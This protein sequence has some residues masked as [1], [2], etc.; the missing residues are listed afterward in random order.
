M[1]PD[2]R[3]D[4]LIDSSYDILWKSSG[5]IDGQIGIGLPADWVQVNDNNSISKSPNLDIDYKYDAFR[6]SM[7]IGMDYVWTGDMRAKNYLT[8]SGA[9]NFLLNTLVNKGQIN[10]EYRHDGTPLNDYVNA[11]TYA[12]NVGWFLPDNSDKVNQFKNNM[13]SEYQKNGNKFMAGTNYYMENLAWM[14]YALATGNAPNI[15][16]RQQAASGAPALLAA[17]VATTPSP[18]TAT[19][20]TPTPTPVSTISATIAPSIQ[21]TDR[22]IQVK[23]PVDN[24]SINGRFTMQIQNTIPNNQGTWWSVDS[25]GWVGMNNVGNNEWVSEIDISGWNWSPTQTYTL[26]GWTK[27]QNGNQIHTQITIHK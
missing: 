22:A 3:W 23:F 7:R 11:A 14:G 24:Q 21:T 25:G 1:N 27:D 8:L 4:K 9:H 2:P 18:T 10:T 17:Q 15:Y 12:V 13:E 16:A 19:F 6:T 26:H 20:A 5:S